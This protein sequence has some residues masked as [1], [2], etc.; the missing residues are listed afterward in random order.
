MRVNVIILNYNGE[1]L[2]PACLPS[3]IS[4]RN[5]SRNGVRIT[6]IDNESTDG[7]LE[8][9]ASYG[10]EIEVR[11]LPNRVLC[12]FNDAV[13]EQEEE[14]AIL[15]N[16]D[17]RVDEGF[18]DPL[19]QVFEDNEDAFMAVPKCF[20]F[21]GKTLEGGRSK[22]FIKYGWF[23][24]VARYE[25]WMDDIDEAGYT[26]QSGFGA[27][28]KDRFLQLEGYDDLY[29]PGRLE[30]S[31]ICFRSWKKGQ[32]SYYQPKSAVYHMGGESFGRKFGK[33]GVSEIDS[34]N[35]AMFFWKN[36]SDPVLWMKHILYMPI[37]IIWWLSRGDASAV[38]GLFQAFLRIP[39]V[40]KRRK[41][42]GKGGLSDKEIFEIFR[43]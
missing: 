14:L 43:G 4:A 34:R 19:V 15:L 2:I 29:L 1:A 5:A 38:K 33:G 40:M 37:R 24:A 23:G 26:F 31:D 32:K 8:V 17:M 39:D 11:R 13:M 36:I 35:S 20:D 3:V 21:E 16:N 7:S 10:S 18:I 27:V 28:R 22:G 6:V 9:L 12:S 41:A 42:L 25:G 30:D